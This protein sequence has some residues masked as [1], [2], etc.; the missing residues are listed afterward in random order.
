[1]EQLTHALHTIKPK[2]DA[3]IL[4]L[5]EV[6]RKLL[7]KYGVVDIDAAWHEKHNHKQLRKVHG[8]VEKPKPED[9]PSNLG[10]VGKYLI[11]KSVFEQLHKIESKS[12]DGEVR[13]IDA[14]IAQKHSLEIYGH[15]LEGTRLDTGT[16]EG[17]KEAVRLLG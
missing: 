16:P 14:L 6:E 1:L 15:I 2:N 3:A 10:I 5:Q 8:L 4:C 7:S 11:P 13:L 17:Y 12:K 9:A